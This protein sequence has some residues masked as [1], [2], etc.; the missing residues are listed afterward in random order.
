MSFNVRPIFY[1]DIA[2]EVA[3]LTETAGAETAQRWAAAVWDTL[4]ELNKNPHLGRARPELPFPGVRS[5]RVAGFGRW[6]V[7]YGVRAKTL[8][9]YRVRHGAMNLI[10]LDFNS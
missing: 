8:V 2:E 7:F 5:W 6:I 10:K 3:Y 4:T 1:D 9:Y